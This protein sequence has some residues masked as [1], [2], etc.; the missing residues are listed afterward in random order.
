MVLGAGGKM[1]FH[2]CLMLKRALAELGDNRR[3]VAVSRFGSAGT[4]QSFSDAGIQWIS[5]DL[6]ESEQVARLPDAEN[7]FFLAGIKF[8]TASNKNLLRLMN[9]Q[10][11]M[12]IASRFARSRIVALSTGCVY[13]FVTPE[14]GG[15]TEASPTEPPGEYARSCIGREQA[16][17]DA[18]QSQGTCS[19]LV[20]LNYSVELRYGVLVDIAQNVLAGNPIDLSTGHVNVI[21]QGDAIEHIIQCLPHASAP[22]FVIN[23]TGS[24]ILSIRDIADWFA[25][26]FATEPSFVGSEA[27]TAWLSNAAKSHSMFGQP[28]VSVQS[29]IEWIAD[30]IKAGGETLGKPTHFQTRDGNY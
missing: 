3:L 15:S 10:L 4:R 24:Q 14:S 20:R 7:L 12:L 9:E 19:A 17:R 6:S 30:W 13:S 1:G 5:A 2:L 26:Q 23:I 25:E 28:K 18:A 16:F 22:P 11:P 29:M 8:G 21:W 27:R